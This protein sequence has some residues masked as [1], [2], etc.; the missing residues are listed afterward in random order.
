MNSQS[1]AKEC[2]RKFKIYV[3]NNYNAEAKWQTG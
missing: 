2:N 3:N 1:Q